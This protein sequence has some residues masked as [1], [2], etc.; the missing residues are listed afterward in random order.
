MGVQHVSKI[1]VY[2]CDK[3]QFASKNGVAKFLFYDKNYKSLK[4]A[5]QTSWM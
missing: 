4:S 2:L 3:I 5:D 1:V